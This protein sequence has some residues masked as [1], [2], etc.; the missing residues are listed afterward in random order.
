MKELIEKIKV[1]GAIF[2]PETISTA[3]VKACKENKV[4]VCNGLLTNDGK[5]RLI[6]LND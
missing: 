1:K 6:Y 3:F 2:V 4:S 5:D